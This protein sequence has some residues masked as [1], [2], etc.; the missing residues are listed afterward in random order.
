MLPAW[1]SK[2][3]QWP[4]P[5]RALACEGWP[6]ARARPHRL[7]LW[8]ARWAMPPWRRW[9]RAFWQNWLRPVWL[10]WFGFPF[11]I[12][13]YG[14]KV[15]GQATMDRP[16][17]YNLDKILQVSI[18]ALVLFSFAAPLVDAA[19]I[20]NLPKYRFHNQQSINLQAVQRVRLRRPEDAIRQ[21]RLD[22]DPILP[23]PGHGL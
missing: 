8:R 18:A 10:S 2:V 20:A 11:R 4:K 5:K 15:T 19:P 23:R 22:R 1:G 6:L 12:L 3:F 14:V 9:P 17:L 16:P 21:D 13:F 7:T